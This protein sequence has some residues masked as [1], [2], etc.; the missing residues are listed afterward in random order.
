MNSN[1]VESAAN[2]EM[3]KEL[4]ADIDRFSLKASA[5]LQPLALKRVLVVLFAGVGFKSLLEGV[6][7]EDEKDIA[8]VIGSVLD[9]MDSVE[10][11]ENLAAIV[12][13]TCKGI[14]SLVECNVEKVYELNQIF[15]MVLSITA[16]DL[17]LG[18]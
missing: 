18:S 13:E 11:V 12:A 5:G 9:Y 3:Y 7:P 1:N 8:P 4:L 10:E 2:F 17:F 15:N 14:R 6:Y 16:E